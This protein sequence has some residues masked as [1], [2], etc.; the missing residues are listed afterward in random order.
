MTNSRRKGAAFERQVAGE[1][2]TYTGIRFKRNLDQYQEKDHG[3]LTPEDP[4]FPFEME[5]KAYASG[6]DCKS[7][8]EAQAFTAAE[9]T[10]KFPAVIYKFNSRPIRVRIWEDALAEAFDT[11][12]LNCGLKVDVS[13][14]DFALIAREIMARRALAKP[15]AV[16]EAMG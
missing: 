11:T 10:G 1:L 5:C 4:G 8:W 9:K 7:G 15:R 14:Q 2:L 16:T 12:P 13:L 6:A 3:D